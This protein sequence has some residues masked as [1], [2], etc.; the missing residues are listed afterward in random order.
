MFKEKFEILKKELEEQELI[1]NQIYKKMNLFDRLSRILYKFNFIYIFSFFLLAMIFLWNILIGNG[2]NF[3]IIYF[4]TGLLIIFIVARISA[5]ITHGKFSKKSS[6][7]Y[8][9]SNKNWLKDLNFNEKEILENLEEIL[10][11][12]S[13]VDIV[14][15]Y[16]SNNINFFISN[17]KEIHKKVLKNNEIN[18]FLRI[19]NFDYEEQKS[20]LLS[21]DIEWLAEVAGKESLYKNMSHVIDD[22]MY[23]KET[24]YYQIIKDIFYDFLEDKQ[25]IEEINKFIEL[26]NQIRQ[27]IKNEKIEIKKEISIIHI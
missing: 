20:I 21:K 5:S 26:K 6:D 14:N 1:K 19:M 12:E 25:Y 4:F 17:I 15:K 3:N 24:Q 27:E 23:K 7:Y 2:I 10:E 18:V 16:F 8:H 11:V 13:S 22:I 9:L